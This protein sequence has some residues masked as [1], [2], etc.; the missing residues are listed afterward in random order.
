MG[1][2]MMSSQVLTIFLTALDLF[3]LVFKTLTGMYLVM[4]TSFIIKYSH[5][6]KN[7]LMQKF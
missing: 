3:Q 5:L 1:V 4:I 7:T 6:K 2:L